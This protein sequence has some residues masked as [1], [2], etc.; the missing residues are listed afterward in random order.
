MHLQRSLDEK[1]SENCRVHLKKEHISHH[2]HPLDLRAPWGPRDVSPRI[3]CEPTTPRPNQRTL[4]SR[5][6]PLSQ[7]SVLYC[8]IHYSTVP[9]SPNSSTALVSFASICKLQA[10]ATQAPASTCFVFS[11]RLEV[12][13]TQA[14]ASTCV[15]FSVRL[16]VVR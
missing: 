10:V 9:S 1:H 3:G 8:I 6:Q 14:P 12:V 15:V 4:V 2:D 5:A 16:E 13:A 7:P 11:V